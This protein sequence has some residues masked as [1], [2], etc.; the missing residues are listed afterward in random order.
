MLRDI[1]LLYRREMLSAL[2]E[3]SVV[4]NSVLIPVFLYPLL[5]WALFSAVIF[6]Q[7][8]TEGFVSRVALVGP[9]T[10]ALARTLER[11]ERFRLVEPPGTGGPRAAVEQGRIDA[12]LE[13]LP[14]DPGARDVAGNYRV[15][16][17]FDGSKDRS[18]TAAQRLREALREHRSRWLQRQ[19]DF[20]GVPAA[21]W[22]GFETAERDQ[23]TREEVGSFLLGMILPTFMVVMV[24]LGSFHPAIDA[25][26]GERERN[27][28]ETL[29]T[30]AVPRPRI[31]VAKYLYV[32]TFGAAA[33][34]LNLAAMVLSMPSIIAPLVRRTGEEL[35]FSL[36]WGA[37]PVIGAGLVL[38]ALFLAAG[39][40][41]LASFARTF[42]EGQTM[43]TPF[44]LLAILP[45]MFLGREGI[46]FNLTLA[47][48]PIVNVTMVFREAIFGVY[49]WPLIAVTLLSGVVVIALC[50]RL[51]AFVLQ[52]EDFVI[53]SHGGS[54]LKF[55]RGKARRRRAEETP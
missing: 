31:V 48:I 17:V 3:R 25:T 28:W 39:M 11:D 19:A 46:E 38:L 52:F 4:V 24:A 41:L 42:R 50:L 34:L 43:V 27:T 55:L 6:V 15:R 30:A 35:S 44:Y 40:M 26:A 14:L 12:A 53:G 47:L 18:A 49:H 13:A 7:G 8:Q 20:R 51:A 45:L 33:G 22:R 10:P 2:R 16:V 21:S 9:V 37:I 29:M 54:L 1:A 23:A 32:A 5:L 36:A